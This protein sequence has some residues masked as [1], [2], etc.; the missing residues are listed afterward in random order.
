MRVR[1]SEQLVNVDTFNNP[2]LRL[3]D[4]G[5][6]VVLNFP[7]EACTTLRREG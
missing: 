4:Y 2:N 3:F 1:L 7:Y 5:E 6:T